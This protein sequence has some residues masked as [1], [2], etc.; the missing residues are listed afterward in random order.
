MNVSYGSSNSLLNT[1]MHK[2]LASKSLCGCPQ[3][4]L[5]ASGYFLKFILKKQN[6][7]TNQQSHSCFPAIFILQPCLTGG[8]EVKA[9]LLLCTVALWLTSSNQI[10]HTALKNKQTN[11]PTNPNHKH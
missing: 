1:L 10:N 3:A 6:N 4:W 8:K 5:L 9:L 7:K 11:Q 2:H